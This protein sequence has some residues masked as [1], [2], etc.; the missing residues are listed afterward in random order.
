MTALQRGSSTLPLGVPALTADFL[1]KATSRYQR[2]LL[3][4]LLPLLLLILLSVAYGQWFAVSL[5]NLGVHV[6]AVPLQVGLIGIGYALFLVAM[7]KLQARFL[8]RCPN[9]QRWINARNVADIV[10]TKHCQWCGA[11]VVDRDS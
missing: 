11:Q 7:A 2:A 3:V 5:S 9:C 6:T 8:P 4:A 10:A 1:F